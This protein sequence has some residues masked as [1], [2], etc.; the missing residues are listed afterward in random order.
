[1]RSNELSEDVEDHAYFSQYGKPLEQLSALQEQIKGKVGLIFTDEPVFE[2]KPI[3]E[4][5]KVKTPAKVGMIAPINVTVPPGPSGLDP[6]QI[7]FFHALH[8]STKIQKG[9]IEILKEVKVREFNPIKI[10]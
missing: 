8:I 6:S 9:Q 2:L 10:A 7:S 3:I 5:H 4:S 1:M